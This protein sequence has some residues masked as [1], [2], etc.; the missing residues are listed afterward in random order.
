MQ[1]KVLV[2]GLKNAGSQFQRMMEWVLRDLPN[3]DPYLDDILVG[4][5]GDSLEELIE[6]HKQDLEKVM[7]TLEEHQL[8]ASPTKSTFFQREVEFCGHILRDGVRQ[9][10]PGKLLPI[11][12]W[13]LPRT[14]TALRGFLGLTNY[15]SE[16]VPNYAETAAPLMSKLKLN[17]LDGKKGSQKPVEW[18][19][20]D[21][22]AF[23]KLKSKL[24]QELG[25][26]Q[27]DLDR[28]FILRADAS[29]HAIGAELCQEIG[30]QVRTVALFSR[31]LGSSQLNWASKEKE[32]YAVVAA[33]HKW[34]GVINFQPVLI[35]TDHK[36]LEHWVTEHVNTPSGP[37]G[38]RAR[39]HEIL[40]EFDIEVQYLP[41]PQNVIADAM[42]RWA[43]PATSSRQDVSWHGSLEGKNEV[44]N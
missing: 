9:P 16:Y 34:S 41:G 32:M 6:N 27:P 44:K 22:E 43:Y 2:M 21:I 18:G 36:A 29:D 15:F 11:Q 30:G 24:A 17:R 25:L 28:P 13:E 3:V 33:L 35:Q 26:H 39:W 42:S 37:R 38:R 19:E 31:K 14:V 8:V 20:T 10:A 40:S 1:W 12:K 23:E 7:K 4:S 5:V